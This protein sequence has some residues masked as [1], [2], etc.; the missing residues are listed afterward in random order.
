MGEGSGGSQ[1]RYAIVP[2]NDRGMASFEAHGVERRDV[3]EAGLRAVL[4]LVYGDVSDD[5]GDFARVIPLR[6]EGDDLAALFVDLLDDLFIQLEE[7]G[8]AL[9]ALTVDGVLQ[10]DRGGFVAWGYGSLAEGTFS[11]LTPPRLL[12]TPCVSSDQ[13]TGFTIRASLMSDV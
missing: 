11:S 3:L 4:E 10:R 2:W 1:C 12:E 5:L 8:A 7:H 13:A 9:R 6:G